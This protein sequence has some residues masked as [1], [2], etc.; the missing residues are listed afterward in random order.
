[1]DTIWHL[2]LHAY[3]KEN[4]LSCNFKS[5]ELAEAFAKDKLQ[6]PTM[7]LSIDQY[8]ANEF[9]RFVFYGRDYFWRNPDYFPE[10]Y[11]MH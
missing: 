2:N 4:S 7:I 1:M 11:E 6:W 9:G 3:D 8:R 10:D 5:L